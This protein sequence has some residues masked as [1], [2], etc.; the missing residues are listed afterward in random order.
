MIDYKQAAE[1]IIK[2]AQNTSLPNMVSKKLTYQQA[3][4]IHLRSQQL[5][6]EC[7]HV[8]KVSDENKRSQIEACYKQ[9]LQEKGY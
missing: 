1:T 4:S 9:R 7:A 6:S 2:N 3:L 8:N 5:A